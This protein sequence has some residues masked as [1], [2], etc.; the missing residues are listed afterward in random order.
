MFAFNKDV[1]KSHWAGRIITVLAILPFLPSAAMK[2][3]M[4]PQVLEGMQHFGFNQSIILPLGILELACV[5]VYLCPPTSAL[6]AILF[7][8]YLGVAICTH[9]RV[10]EPVPVQIVLGVLIWL[11]LYLREPRL[12]A[13]IPNRCRQPNQ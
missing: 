11:G 1:S 8:G 2:L 6:G 3:L 10:G 12:R 7:T 13:L 9:V 4:H 5:A